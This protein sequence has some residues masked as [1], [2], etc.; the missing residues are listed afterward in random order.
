MNSCEKLTDEVV[1]FLKILATRLPSDVLEALKAAYSAEENP[2][3]RNIYEAYLKNIQIAKEKSVP[4]CQDTG[5]AMF[6]VKVGTKFPYIDYIHQALIK[7]TRRATFEVPLRPNAVNPFSHQNSG[8]NTGENVPFI[9]IEL[10]PGGDKLEIYGYLSGGG[11]SLPGRAKVLTP[12]EFS[13]LDGLMEFIVDTV[14]KYGPNACS[15]LLVGVG[16]GATAEI[17]AVL[18]KKALLRKIGSRHPRP[19]VAE[20]ELSLKEKLNSL[21]IGPQGIGGKVSVLDVF[22]EYSYTHP[23]TR[24]V[25]INVGCWATRR[26][27]MV[28]N[29]DLSFSIPTHLTGEDAHE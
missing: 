23:A 7:G 16:I 6:F 10:V 28:V 18:S 26:G 5:V 29:S 20:L 17:A 22:V 24:A 2:V 11:S 27:L 3:A 4:V 14:A 19:E 13:G 25:G 15:P 1:Y 21:N 12:A 9:D 8:D